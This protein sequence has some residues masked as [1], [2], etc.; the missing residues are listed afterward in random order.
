MSTP[1]G[2]HEPGNFQVLTS[3]PQKPSFVDFTSLL[4]LAY[5]V[6]CNSSTSWCFSCFL[7]PVNILQHNILWQGV[8]CKVVNTKLK[9]LLEAE[10]WYSS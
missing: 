6:T 5:V 10:S 3:Y 1:R 8:L 4:G 2:E 9:P 7:S